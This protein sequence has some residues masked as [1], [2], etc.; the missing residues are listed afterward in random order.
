MRNAKTNIEFFAKKAKLKFENISHK[1]K[2]SGKNF[3]MHLEMAKLDFLKLQLL[4]FYCN[5]KKF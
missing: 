2:S 1:K 4:D 5:K 3:P